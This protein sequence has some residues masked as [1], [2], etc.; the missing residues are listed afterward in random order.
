LKTNPHERIKKA[1]PWSEEL[2]EDRFSG[3]EVIEI[4]WS[5]DRR[6]SAGEK[7][8]REDDTGEHCSVKKIAHIRFER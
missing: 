3:S 1:L 2:N 5:K 8:K 7:R 4:V 6:R